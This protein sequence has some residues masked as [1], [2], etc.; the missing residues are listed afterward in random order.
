MTTR[1]DMT[2]HEARAL[3]RKLF[4][5]AFNGF[6]Q[7]GLWYVGKFLDEAPAHDGKGPPP[8]PYHRKQEIYGCG[9]T[10]K[11]AFAFFLGP[12]RIYSIPGVSPG[13][14]RPDGWRPVL[15]KRT[16]AIVGWKSRAGVF[17]RGR[18]PGRPVVQ[19]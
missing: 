14:L 12:E 18:F 7:G 8:P 16:N 4:G 15:D 17:T 11:E 13:S 1:E 10:L 2:I 6:C 3:G 9:E 5:D 19:A